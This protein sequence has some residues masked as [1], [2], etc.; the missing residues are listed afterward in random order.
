MSHRIWWLIAVV[1]LGIGLSI[2]Q[3]PRAGVDAAT[4]AEAAS[5][6]LTA[7]PLAARQQPARG[8]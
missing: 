5:A 6:T 1:A 2:E 7:E 8:G 4:K 3:E